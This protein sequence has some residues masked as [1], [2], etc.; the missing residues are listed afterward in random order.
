MVT[1]DF[2][3]RQSSQVRLM[4]ALEK[5]IPVS[6]Q[7][8]LHSQ[9]LFMEKAWRCFDR[10]DKD[11]DGAALLKALRVACGLLTSTKELEQRSR[12]FRKQLRDLL[13]EYADNVPLEEF[14]QLF[15]PAVAAA[16]AAGV[17]LSLPELIQ[18]GLWRMDV[19][20]VAALALECSP[21]QRQQML[22]ARA[23]DSMSV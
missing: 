17:T 7:G 20:A 1:N 16:A 6:S 11:R 18:D 22:T 4:Q 3:A 9:V 10:M 15:K 8:T 5:K 14:V 12:E 13:K 23:L 21:D 19:A 2:I